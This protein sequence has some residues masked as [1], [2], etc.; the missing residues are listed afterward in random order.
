MTDPGR[1]DPAAV[2]GYLLALQSDIVMALEALDGEPFL[3][4]R[5]T[6][7]EGGGGL[8]RVIEEGRLFERGGVNFSRVHGAGL[9]PSASAARPALA[10]RR[11]DANDPSGNL[12]L[13]LALG[14]AFLLRLELRF[15]Q[16]A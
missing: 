1:P 5:W 11:F 4:D 12:A 14:H 2:E 15:S 8:T 7:P 6:R 9:P 10:G 3:S 13:Q 16:R